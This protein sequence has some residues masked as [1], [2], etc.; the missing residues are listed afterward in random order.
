M[1]LV[2]LGLSAC[3]RRAPQPEP[4]YPGSHAPVPVELRQ[5]YSGAFVY[6]GGDAERT[7]VASAVN[8]AVESMSFFA[9]G[10]ARNA[11]LARAAIR[12]SFTISFDDAGNV[13]VVSPGEFPEVSPADGTP[14]RMVNR[15]GDE[16][17]L[18]QQFV[19][20][21]L[22][23]RGRSADGGGSTTFA[24]QPDQRTLLVRRTME[25]TQLSRPVEYT[26]TYRRQ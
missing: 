19:A 11:L 3:A 17:E 26:L 7:A 23:Q 13:S 24:L 2:V 6:S 12:D 16:T 25:S 10:F 1:V 21:N 4:V 18:T 8:H 15:F 5:R 20:G 14:V 9:R 22:V